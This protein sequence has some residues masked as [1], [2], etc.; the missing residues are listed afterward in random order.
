MFGVRQANR[1]AGSNSKT[2][3]SYEGERDPKRE[4]ERNG[5]RDSGCYGECSGERDGKRDGECGS[6]RDGDRYGERDGD[7]NRY[8]NSDGECQ[9]KNCTTDE[10]NGDS[11]IPVMERGME[12][13]RSVR[14]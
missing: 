14:E 9:H 5:E 11:A 13:A 4:S 3:D 2:S 6:E 7:V 10:D 1:R 8:G 12:D